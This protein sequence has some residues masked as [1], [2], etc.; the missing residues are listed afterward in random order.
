MYYF[1]ANGPKAD[2]NPEAQSLPVEGRGAERTSTTREP[3]YGSCDVVGEE[4][5]VYHVS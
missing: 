4:L 1:D 5:S 3:R 2:G